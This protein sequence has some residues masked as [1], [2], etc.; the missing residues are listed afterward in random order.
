MKKKK[1]LWGNEFLSH[2]WAAPKWT[3][4]AGAQIK[5]VTLIQLLLQKHH[6]NHSSADKTGSFPLESTDNNQLP[7]SV[8]RQRV[9]LH[10]LLS[11]MQG[12]NPALDLHSREK[13]NST[14]GEPLWLSWELGQRPERASSRRR[15]RKGFG[16]ADTGEAMK[17]SWR[18]PSSQAF[19]CPSAFC[20]KTN[21][22]EKKRGKKR[23]VW[24]SNPT[25]IFMLWT[26]GLPQTQICEQRL[27]E[28]G[29]VSESRVL[30]LGLI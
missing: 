4:S 11:C 17:L 27:S 22:K 19:I 7:P 15:Q 21:R 24:L 6:P 16:A 8:Y 28:Q 30:G 12:H 2:E 29:G 13:G 25:F 10:C 5:A 23:E 20:R 9:N 18:T 26:P 3:F 14:I 1:K